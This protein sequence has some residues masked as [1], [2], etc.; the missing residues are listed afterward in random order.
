MDYSQMIGG[1]SW[2]P[3]I[4]APRPAEGPKVSTPAL[5]PEAPPT[6]GDRLDIQGMHLDAPATAPI[7]AEVAAV[8]SEPVAV[9][10]ARTGA[11]VSLLA[12]EVPSLLRGPDCTCSPIAGLGVLAQFDEPSAVAGV[13]AIDD[14]P[15]V[16]GF[17]EFSLIGPG[18]AAQYLADPSG[19][20]LGL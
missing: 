15:R 8:A 13:R 7:P 3:G 12:E 1:H 4:K 6:Q 14:Q 16:N 18:N 5:A 9:A 17:S 2:N 10:P 19:M 11:P 20:Y